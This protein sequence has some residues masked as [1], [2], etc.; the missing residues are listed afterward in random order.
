MSTLKRLNIAQSAVSDL[1]PLKGLKLERITLTPENI[2]T[3]ME[4]IREMSSLSQILT[5]MQGPGQSAADFWKK[6]DDGVWSSDPESDKDNQSDAPEET[7]QESANKPDSDSEPTGTES[8][9]ENKESKAD[10]S[11]SGEEV[12]ADGSNSSPDQ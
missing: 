8:P 5:S 10:G 3:G 4:V 1:T 12:Q 9:S 2:K 11:K 6:Y 7:P